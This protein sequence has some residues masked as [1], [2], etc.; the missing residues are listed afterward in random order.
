RV[1]RTAL[2]SQAMNAKWSV[3]SRAGR[4]RARSRAV[5]PGA[6]SQGGRIDDREA[7]LGLHVDQH[8]VA[9][10][11]VGEVAGLAAQLHRAAHGTGSGVDDGLGAGG[12]VDGPHAG[13]D[14]VVGQAIG[15]L[16]SGRVL[17]LSSAAVSSSRATIWLPP[18]AVA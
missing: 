4:G 11:V 1:S 3:G 8:R 12:F 14:R 6:G 18:V 15:I 16:T 7:V 17:R 10:G 13:V 2:S 5:A 9:G